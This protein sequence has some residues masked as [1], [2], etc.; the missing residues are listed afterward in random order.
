MTL[1][2]LTT[3]IITHGILLIHDLNCFADVMVMMVTAVD[4]DVGKN[5]EIEYSIV[6]GEGKD[7]YFLNPVT[8]ELRLTAELELEDSYTLRVK[9][10]DKG[11]PSRSTGK[12][13]LEVTFN[14]TQI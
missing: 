5:A 2:L 13:D 4:Y 3:L 6:D 9:A 11:E 1:P 10:Q 7:K 8:G 14:N 12:F